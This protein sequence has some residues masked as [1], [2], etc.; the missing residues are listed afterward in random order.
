[1]VKVSFASIFFLLSSLSSLSFTFPIK[2]RTVSE[3]E[4]DLNKLSVD[5]AELASS[6][7]AVVSVPDVVDVTVSGRPICRTP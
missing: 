7:N 6:V 5:V 1:M 3:L 2:P 4:T